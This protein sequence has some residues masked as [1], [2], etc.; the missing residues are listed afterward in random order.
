MRFAWPAALLSTILIAGRADVATLPKVSPIWGD[1]LPG[2]Y[3]V[4]LVVLEEQDGARPGLPIDSVTVTSGGRPMP[5]VVWYPAT[6]SSRPRVTLREYIELTPAGLGAAVAT[7]ERRRQATEAF[8][9]EA[10]AS[11]LSRPRVDSVM[12]LPMQA[13]REAPRKAGRFPLVVFLHATP[14]GASVMSEYL[15]SHGFVVAAI[16]SKGARQ[17][18]Y[19]L[20]RENLDA[21]VEDAM[22][23]VSRM[24]EETDISPRLGVI[25]MS[26]GAIAAM[27][28]EPGGLRGDAIVSLDGGIG[29]R[30]GGTY[31]HERSEGHPTRFTV[32]VLHLYTPENP[33]LDLQY[34]RSYERSARML[35]RIG[36]LRHADFLTDG[37][38]ERLLPGR[39]GPAPQGAAR[40]FSTAC[41]YTLQ[42]LRWR[43]KNDSGAKRF[44]TLTPEA[45]GVPAGWMGIE[46]LPATAP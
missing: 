19:R 22:F 18:A 11:G 36:Q 7:L 43:L 37:A 35:A 40:G 20:S 25:G 12:A 14:W 39:A 15:A 38:L 34:L 33:H 23:T 4:G 17:A 3:A 45:N 30:A 24:R 5:I 10:V 1:L 29:E 6:T 44:L 42:F 2:P 28:L 8:A 13:V 21:M 26:N 31:L 27:A 41:R 32:P 46:R 16:Q 9:A